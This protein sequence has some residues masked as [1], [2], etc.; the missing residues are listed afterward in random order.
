[1]FLYTGPA[2]RR[3]GRGPANG[4][5]CII[6]QACPLRRAESWALPVADGVTV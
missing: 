3:A 2:L 4:A 6:N 5:E 1:M